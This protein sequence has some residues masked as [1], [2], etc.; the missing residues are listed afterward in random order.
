MMPTLSELTLNN[1]NPFPNLF[2]PI[3][4]NQMI[5]R[6]RIISTPI[7]AH[8]ST[9]KATGG[10]GLF[11]MGSGAVND[12]RAAFGP[13]P[14]IFDKYERQ[15]TR[16]KLDMF[17]QG[18]G[19]IS[20]EI[21]HSGIYAR[22]A[23]GDF[24]WGPCDG[25]REDGTP[26]RALDEAEMQRV[27]DLF[28]ETA[29]TARDF[30][31]DMVMLHFAHGWLP[32]EFLSP[33]WNHRTDAY[34]G[35]FENRARFPKRIIETVRKAVG[36]DFPIDMRISAYEWIPESIAFADV[37]RFIQEV[38]PLLD[39]VNVSAG[40]DINH[41]G[42]VHMA[43]TA[44]EPHMPNVHWAADI[45]KQVS[46]PI[47]VVGAIMTPEEGE[48]IIASGKSDMVSLGRML[49]A[50][51]Q[52]AR[53]A[54]ESHSE[55]IVPCLRC[56]YCY[57]IS[58]NRMNVGCAVNPRFG[59]ED[60]IPYQINKAE[61]VKK[62]VVVGGG[63]GG[64]KAALTAAER[65]HRVILL[66]R[67]DTLGGKLSVADYDDYKQDLKRYRDYLKRQVLRSDIDVRLNTKATAEMICRLTPDAL[68]VAVGAEVTMP[69]IPGVENAMQA[70]D[71]YPRLDELKGRI[72]VIGGG[73]IGSEIALELAERGNP[74][75]LI[76]L[77]DTLNAQ[78]NMLYRI[79]IR[80]HMD[81]CPDLHPMLLTVCR[82]IQAKGV[83]VGNKDGEQF[84]AADHVI[85]ATGMKAKRDLA[86]SFFG[87]VQDTFLIGDCNRVGN[88]KDAVE[89]A[90][91]IAMNI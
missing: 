41:E 55:D 38:E 52:W 81:Q 33:A 85:L 31:F 83:V 58:T 23:P 20:L 62:I 35:C 76:E 27:C 61:K 42:N 68:F 22:V 80:Q 2:Q 50:D 63:P 84:I 1:Q 45:K 73:T 90:T 19:R 16:A 75:Y 11:I 37:I 26:I 10:A 78:G 48:E 5:L 15:A 54:Y 89:S 88:V 51:P 7:G 29:V 32:A 91:M 57:H 69:P 36:K 67:E 53:K 30:G 64:M 77:T 56:L 46:I 70:L 39:M 87:I 74:V 72:V 47:S 9:E 59:K 49:V 43:T 44:F 40:L 28:A 12:P 14:Y 21:M 82:E 25:V 13:I 60:L 34:G 4:I 6:N 71:A 8:C 3:K 65:G 17:H 86:N 18:G 24:V 66:E 79:A